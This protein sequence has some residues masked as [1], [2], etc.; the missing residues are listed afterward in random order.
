MNLKTLA[1]CLATIAATPAIACDA[2]AVVP[3]E[4]YG[5][6]NKGRYRELEDVLKNRDAAQLKSLMDSNVVAKIAPG[7][8]VCI[9]GGDFFA[10]L[11]QV[12]APGW[13]FKY[14]VPDRSVE[15]VD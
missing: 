5:S 4:T 1:I 12:S 10:Y 14:W 8:K 2:P 6:V 3:K 13:K 15:K 7:T 9:E 11:A